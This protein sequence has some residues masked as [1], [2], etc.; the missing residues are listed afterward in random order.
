MKINWKSWFQ[1]LNFTDEPDEPD[2]IESKNVEQQ[3]PVADAKISRPASTSEL[4]KIR[5]TSV[6]SFAN[7]RDKFEQNGNEG[8]YWFHEFFI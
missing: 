1:F 3:Q 8:M 2:Q 4:P 5:S 6:T 7:L